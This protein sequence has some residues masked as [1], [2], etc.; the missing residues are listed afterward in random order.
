[1]PSAVKPHALPGYV[2]C[3]ALDLHERNH[4]VNLCTPL[5]GVGHLSGVGGVC[6]AGDPAHAQPPSARKSSRTQFTDIPHNIYIER[7]QV[8]DDNTNQHWIQDD[9]SSH[10][11]CFQQLLHSSFLPLSL[12]LTRIFVKHE[13]S[14]VHIF[15]LYL[16]SR[17]FVACVSVVSSPGKIETGEVCTSRDLFSTTCFSSFFLLLLHTALV[18]HTL[19][20]FKLFCN[21]S[22]SNGRPSNHRACLS[23]R[24]WE[25]SQL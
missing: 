10:L 18:L 3:R 14:S 25:W 15:K 6:V 5:I 13:L 21:E 7:L 11:Q 8:Y 2:S 1:M 12:R 4:R 19:A 20:R 17:V 24:S 22:R 9:T 16:P 23:K